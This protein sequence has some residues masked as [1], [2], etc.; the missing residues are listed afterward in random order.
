MQNL[1]QIL[2]LIGYGVIMGVGMG[3]SLWI[4]QAIGVIIGG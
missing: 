3:L 2:T 4:M 1:L